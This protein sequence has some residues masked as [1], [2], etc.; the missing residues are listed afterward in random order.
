M[1]AGHYESPPS[2]EGGYEKMLSLICDPP[3]FSRI[4]K[5]AV[6]RSELNR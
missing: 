4:I 2:G 6:R 5:V 1:V 3:P